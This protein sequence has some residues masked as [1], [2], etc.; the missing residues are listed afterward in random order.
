M[1]N[2]I[3]I[4][5]LVAI[6]LI[7]VAVAIEIGTIEVLMGAMLIVSGSYVIGTNIGCE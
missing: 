5:I 1:K 4:A 2:A 7:S 3:I 6:S